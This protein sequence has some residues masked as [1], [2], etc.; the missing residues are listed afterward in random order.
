MEDR[1]YCKREIN[2]RGSIDEVIENLVS[3]KKEI[4]DECNILDVKFY[5]IRFCAEYGDEYLDT[6]FDY[7]R[8]KTEKEKEKEKEETLA[9]EKI[10]K[11]REIKLL[12]ELAEK[13]RN[14]I[15]EENL[16]RII[17]EKR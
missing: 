17:D 4:E 10:Q 5:D 8:G 3:L 12:K 7:F 9:F 15:T 1:I 2:L 16:G 6:Y 14:E 13:Y 11:E